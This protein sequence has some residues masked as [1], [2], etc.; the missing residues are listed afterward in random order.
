MP[1]STLCGPRV[2]ARLHSLVGEPVEII[3][4]RMRY[5]GRL[6]ALHPRAVWLELNDD[7]RVAIAEPIVT[8]VR[9][10]DAVPGARPHEHPAVTPP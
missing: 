9:R 3:T 2:H 5:C 7:C 10:P 6:I 4:L 8:V 1:T